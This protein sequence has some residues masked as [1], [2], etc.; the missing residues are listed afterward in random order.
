MLIYFK[1][2]LRIPYSV[3]SICRCSSHVPLNMTLLGSLVRDI[4]LWF[5][6]PD[7]LQLR[8]SPFSGF[9][10]Q[11][12]LC[13]IFFA[14]LSC[15][16]KG[17]VCIFSVENQGLLKAA[18]EIHFSLCHLHIGIEIRLSCQV[19]SEFFPKSLLQNTQPRV[20]SCTQ[21]I[22]CLSLGLVK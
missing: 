8:H 10:A 1:C 7:T 12:S 5:L 19:I 15:I 2:S 3:F 14:L 20:I 6:S 11:N 13:A 21:Q 9:S 16:L 4:S 22:R 17:S 18:L